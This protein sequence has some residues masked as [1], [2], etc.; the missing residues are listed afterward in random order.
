MERDLAAGVAH[1]GAE[2]AAVLLREPLAGDQPQPEVGRHGAVAGVV[3]QPGGQV[4]IGLLE[5]VGGVDTALAAGDRAA[6]GPSAGDAFGDV[7]RAQRVPLLRPKRRET[8]GLQ[9]HPSPESS[10]SPYK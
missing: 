3:G 9:S 4:E 6:A 5:D 2:V 10:L 8:R 7:P 1:R